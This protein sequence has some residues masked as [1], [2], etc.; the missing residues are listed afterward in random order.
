MRP[1]P[2]GLTSLGLLFG[3]SLGQFGPFGPS[4]EQ[5]VRYSVIDSG[6][7]SL[8]K[9]AK[10]ILIM[11]QD[12]LEDYWAKVLGRSRGD[13]PTDIDFVT[14]SVVAIHVGTRRNG[15]YSL[16]IESVR[17][18]PGGDIRIRWMENT[19]APGTRQ[20]MIVSSPW[21]LLRIGSTVGNIKYQKVSPPQTGTGTGSCNCSCG[22]AVTGT[23][24]CGS[25]R[26]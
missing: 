3:L 10:Q 7:F 9:D 5:G 19:P 18:I 22:C 15:G 17:R 1:M 14:N 21:I 8:L 13:A 24:T 26:S 6:N 23:C 25:Q 11:R 16:G 20:P 2:M 4:Q 12:Q